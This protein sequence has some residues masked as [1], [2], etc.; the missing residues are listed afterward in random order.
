MISKE[1]E[2]VLTEIAEN[3]IDEI[4]GYIAIELANPDAASDFADKLE[5][6]LAKLCKSPKNGRP[7][8]NEFLK[9]DDVRRILVG[10][11]IVYYII[12]D[13]KDLIVVLR[14]VY[15]RRD[16]GQILKDV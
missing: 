8:E 13:D 1:Y 4:F 14:V 2:Y 5:K 12:D 16:Q 11:Y 15:N 9:R 6:E 3:D 7:V 10:N